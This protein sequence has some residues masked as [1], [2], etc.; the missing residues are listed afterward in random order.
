MLEK[1]FTAINTA[2]D[3]ENK[4]HDNA[5]AP[6]YGFRGGLVPGV[7]IFDY[8]CQTFEEEHGDLWRTQGW[9]ELRLIRPFYDGEQVLIK[10]EPSMGDCALSAEGDDG[11][12][13]AT[14]RIGV[15]NTAAAPFD[16]DASPLPLERPAAAEAALAPGTA[17]GSIAH[18]L[19]T[20]SPRELLELANRI[21]MANVVLEPWVHT[22]SKLQWFAAPR[23]GQ[24]V[25]VRAAVDD[26]F[27]RK[28]HSMV[29]YAVAYL[30]DGQP[31]LH[32]DHT[33]IW[34]LQRVSS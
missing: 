8:L 24:T 1:T 21:L 3:S 23:I 10:S 5:I 25:E 20:G 16:L 15:R 22:A 30:S 31:L 19:Q 28:G 18:V 11:G 13:R 6:A 17:L 14:L 27:A 9:G 26:L 34:R 33:V 2:P 29:R 4:M 7:D 12:V 32:V